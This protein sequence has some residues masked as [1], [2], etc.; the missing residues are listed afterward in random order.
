MTVGS[1]PRP[2]SFTHPLVRAAVVDLASAPQRR[3]AHRR[4]SRLARDPHVRTLHLADSVMGTDD[5]VAA[6]LDDVADTALG[7]GDAAAAVSVL[8][9]AADLTAHAPARARR[10]ATAAYLGANVSGTLSGAP[11]LLEQARAVDPDAMDTLQ[12]ATAA[13]AHLLNSDGGV[14]TAHQVLVQALAAA[15]PDGQD[16]VVEAAVHTLMIVCA[17]GG[18]RT[19]WSAFEDAVTRSAGR[20]SP[21]LR[22]AAVTFADPAR[23]TAEQLAEL[24]V[25]VASVDGAANPVR[26]L[27]VAVAGQYVDREPASA[28]DEVV[29][30]AR[31]GGPVALAVQALV[32]RAMTALHEGRWGD[33]AALSDEGVALC[34][35]HGYRLLEWG[36]LNPRMLLA[37]ARGDTGYLVGVRER[38]HQW[39]LPR[40]MMAARTF[41]AN[42][43]GLAALS[44]G[45]YGDAY[46][47]YASIAEPGTFPPYEQVLLWN[48]LDVVEAAV[49]SG[50]AEQA[51]RHTVAA[52]TL[53]HISPRLRFQVEAADA[54]VAPPEEYS[55]RFDRLVLDPGST[56]WPFHLARLELAYG[57]RLRRDRAMRRAR[58]HLERAHELFTTL[59]AEPWTT[60]TEAAFRA[61]G[62]S[63]QA[64]ADGGPPRLTP[65]EREVVSLAASGLT[66]KE[67]GGRLHLSPRT[68]GAHLYRAF[69][70][71][72]VTSRAGL[73]D[74]LSSLEEP[75]E[76]DGA[77]VQSPD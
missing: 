65:Q 10:L 39:A 60:R 44:E 34:A 9:R 24:D 76:R 35:E 47:T 15:P 64:V 40:R 50:H 61:T 71:L 54:L 25:M 69:P 46:A 20:L 30:A 5:E 62:R 48:V 11:A 14:D 12:A 55:A 7:T 6:L 58:P 27:E 32:M 59:G 37:A 38:L 19:L 3:S 56:R 67:I 41:T 51:R 13:A 26:T 68:V 18:R 72:G 16:P 63:R 70:K 21:E 53:A 73:R 42:V 66:N 8:L 4:L 52:E 57:E 45:R 28:L 75:D 2:L 31:T 23:A 1:G 22:L 36:V 74:A 17:F 33:A 43:D 49:R 29:L 77:S